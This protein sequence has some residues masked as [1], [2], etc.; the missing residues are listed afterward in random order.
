MRKTG[1]GIQTFASAPDRA[2][3]EMGATPILPWHLRR[4]IIV[5]L[6]VKAALLLLLYF[7]FFGPS[8]RAPQTAAA[9][10]AHIFSTAAQP[11][12]PR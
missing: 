7:L 5:L 11:A 4:D 10:D 6:L 3:A 8:Q 1:H 12:H 2:G 9:I